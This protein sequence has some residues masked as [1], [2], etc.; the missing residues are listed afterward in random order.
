MID[1]SRCNGCFDECSNCDQDYRFKAT[2]QIYNLTDEEFPLNFE[3]QD[4]ANT[5]K[6]VLALYRL[7]HSMHERDAN[8]AVLYDLYA[9]FNWYNDY[10]ALN[11]LAIEACINN[12]I[13][14]DIPKVPS[15]IAKRLCHTDPNS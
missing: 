7:K 13:H 6:G 9:D 5:L 12:N 10:E 3:A 1:T 2:K 15:R 8:Q 14:I 4:N 11:I